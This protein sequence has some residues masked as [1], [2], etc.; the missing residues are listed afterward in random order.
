MAEWHLH[1][2]H[3]P[4]FRLSSLTI[5]HHQCLHLEISSD[6]YWP[7]SWASLF[8]AFFEAPALWQRNRSWEY[9]TFAFG[10]RLTLTDVILASSDDNSSH[11]YPINSHVY[12]M[13]T[14]LCMVMSLDW[15]YL[16][17]GTGNNYA[18]LVTDDKTK[19]S[20]I[21]DPANPPEYGLSISWIG[22]GF[23][24]FWYRVLPVLKQQTD[25]GNIKLT[26]IV[27]THQYDCW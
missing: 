3:W 9:D 24:N 16:G 11:A 23:A 1:F 13:K 18:Y 17:E 4:K 7:C 14:R 22:I 21:I 8:R 19:E 27:N 6:Y 5:H 12:E 2:R 25:S 15:L 26:S 20:V 10:I